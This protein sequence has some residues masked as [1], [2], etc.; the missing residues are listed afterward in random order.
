MNQKSQETLETPDKIIKF[1][2]LLL[3]DSKEE[4]Y[5]IRHELQSSPMFLGSCG[6]LFS[7]GA[8]FASTIGK[9]RTSF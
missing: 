9:K 5:Q 7:H 4:E 8:L 3:N 2:S 6:A 1:D